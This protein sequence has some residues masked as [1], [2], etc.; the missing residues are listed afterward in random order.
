MT[1]MLALPELAAVSAAHP[2]GMRYGADALTQ[3]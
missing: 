2:S 1:G 3:T